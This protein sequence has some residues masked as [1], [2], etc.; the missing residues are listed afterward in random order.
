MMQIALVF[1]LVKVIHQTESEVE[2]QMRLRAILDRSHIIS[3]LYYD[4]GVA[5][6][7]YSVSKSSVFMDR[8]NRIVNQLPID[9]EALSQLVKDDREKSNTVE[10]IKKLVSDGLTL[11]TDTKKF[12]DDNR[13]DIAE[14]K[15]RNTY[16]RTKKSANDLQLSLIHI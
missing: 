14:Y 2:N 3:R 7:G 1:A 13:A 10:K 5:M 12:V 11:L 9:L 6:G 15:A 16:Q 4:A 8:Y